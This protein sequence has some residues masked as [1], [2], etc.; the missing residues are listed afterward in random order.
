LYGAMYLNFKR[1][2]ILFP[3]MDANN[4]R[5]V[6]TKYKNVK[7]INT[8]IGSEICKK[9][10][11]SYSKNG[12]RHLGDKNPKLKLEYEAAVNVLSTT[13]GQEISKVLPC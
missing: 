3:I 5:V 12:N 8:K 6:P 1:F 2:A 4:E 13:Q 11:Y 9:Y 7:P 10:S